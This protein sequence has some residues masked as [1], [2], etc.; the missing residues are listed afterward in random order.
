AQ[1]IERWRQ[2]VGFVDGDDDGCDGHV[3]GVRLNGSSG[4]T[5]RKRI[6]EPLGL[7]MTD[8]WLTDAV[9][10][11]FVKCGTRDRREQGDVI[12]EVYNPF[13]EVAGRPVARLPRRP[14]PRRLIAVAIGRE[15][16]RLRQELLDS[17]AAVVFT[18]GEEA[19]QVL[20]GVVD[21]VTGPP[22][23]GL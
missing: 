9:P 21:N 1:L 11:F 3:A 5:V 23:Q 20:A 16:A 19:R 22:A 4:L 15:Q 2:A 12:D 6:I 18:L 13:A 8:V 10:W 14:S 17:D 7:A